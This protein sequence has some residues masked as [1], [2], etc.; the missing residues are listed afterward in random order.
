LTTEEFSKAY[1]I[2]LENSKEW[3]YLPTIEM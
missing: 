3:F 2:I 1:N